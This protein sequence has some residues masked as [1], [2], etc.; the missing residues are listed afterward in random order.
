ML[1][2]KIALKNKHYYYYISVI[3]CGCLILRKSHNLLNMSMLCCSSVVSTS[4]NLLHTF[5]ILTKTIA[6][7]SLP[8]DEKKRDF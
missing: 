4:H 3:L 5:Y 7:A 8:L 1:C 6:I 2:G